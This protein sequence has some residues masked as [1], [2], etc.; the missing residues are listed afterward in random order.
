MQEDTKTLDNAWSRREL[1]EAGGAT[2]LVVG[3]ASAQPAPQAVHPAAGSSAL[4]RL[5]QDMFPHRSL[6]PAVYF[7]L[8]GQLNLRADAATKGLFASGVAELNRA[9]GGSWETLPT[10]KRLEILGKQANT[11]FFQVFRMSV[12][13]ALYADL[14]VVKKFGYEGPSFARGGYLTR[15]YDDLDWLEEPTG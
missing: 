3:T 4:V 14:E 13:T 2:L 6:E 8:V 5:A 10:E 7:G 9:A 11:S 12:L 15:G 1:L